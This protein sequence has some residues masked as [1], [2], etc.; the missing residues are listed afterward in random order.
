MKDGKLGSSFSRVSFDIPSSA[1]LIL[2]C[3][4]NLR[5]YTYPIPTKHINS[6]TRLT[7]TTSRSKQKVKAITPPPYARKSCFVDFE[8]CLE[9]PAAPSSQSPALFQALL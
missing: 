7:E 5:T 8:C 6:I 2:C 3:I 9:S 4:L 1:L